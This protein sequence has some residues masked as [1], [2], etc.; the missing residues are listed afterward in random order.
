MLAQGSVSHQNSVWLQGVLLW[1]VRSC[2]VTT[3]WRLT[4]SKE[5]LE[6]WTRGPSAK[7][8]YAHTR[9]TDTAGYGVLGEQLGN[10][11]WWNL[12]N[13]LRTMLQ[14]CFL[15]EVAILMS[16]KA[17][18]ALAYRPPTCNNNFILSCRNWYLVSTG[19]NKI[20]GHTTCSKYMSQK[21]THHCEL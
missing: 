6:T 20:M 16:C 11:D 9:L 10:M 13:C 5:V 14:L 18:C 1:F 8:Q 4:G 7:L 3:L 17:L 2:L 21:D 15:L 12:C 19:N